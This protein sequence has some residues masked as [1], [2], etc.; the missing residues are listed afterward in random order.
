MGLVV[1]GKVASPGSGGNKFDLGTSPLAFH[2]HV[3]AGMGGLVEHSRRS[4]GRL[5]EGEGRAPA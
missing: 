4:A 1:E 3:D 2:V 5:A